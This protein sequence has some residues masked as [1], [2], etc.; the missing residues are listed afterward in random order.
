[1]DIFGSIADGF[2]VAL[3]PRNL[4]WVFVGVLVGMIIGVMPG[5]GPVP[6][7]TLLLPLT[8]E[9]PPDSAIILLAGVYYGAM[10]GGTIT[11][12]LLKLPG[13]AASVVTVI[14]GYQMARQGRAGS[15]LG[16]AAIGSF[17]GGTVSILGLTFGAPLLARYA[18]NFGP[19]EYTVLAMLGILLV[20]TMTTGST[21]KAIIAAAAGLLLAAIG[22]DQF[23]GVERFTGGVLELSDGLDFV[24]V[25]MGLFGL[26]E[27]FYALDHRVRQRFTQV[28][29]ATKWP[30][31][32]DLHDSRGAITRGSFLGFVLG[33][34]PG[35]SGTLSSMA[36]YALE[37]RVSKTPERF[38][39]GAIEGVAGPETAN[40]AAATSSFIPLLTLGI[41]TNPVMAVILGG[42]MLQGI[43]PGPRLITENPAV[44][45]GVIDSMYIGNVLLLIMSI[46]LVGLFVK[47]IS[48]RESI[49][50]SVVI[51][52][53]MLGTY[54]I[55]NT[56]FDMWIV[57]GF[58]VLGYLMKKTGFD[59]GP[60]LL[61]FVLG[62]VLEESLRRSLRMFDGDFAGFVTRPIS[63]TLIVIMGIAIIAPFVLKR[64]R[65]AAEK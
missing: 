19:P 14:D 1:M 50:A 43:A 65:R 51:A 5:L 57:I 49:L 44:F 3:A 30:S 58:G 18:L 37:R 56:V 64:L 17:I 22:L 53:V 21:V 23:V 6:T 32:Q 16:I 38:G 47:L 60:L 34:L 35:G 20:A 4:L 28:R 46:P 48:V 15:A 8:Y 24:A 13:E 39:K 59:P 54:T 7:I 2:A 25:A 62:S 52:V 29:L 11:S 9:I 40:N 41:P 55:S 26:G 36:S 27:I 31:R 61:A 10:Y 63:G 45:W 33:I 42:L 12:V